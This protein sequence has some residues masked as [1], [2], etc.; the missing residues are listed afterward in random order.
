MHSKLYPTY[1]R[2]HHEP[3]TQ[4]SRRCLEVDVN[5]QLNTHTSWLNT[6]IPDPLSLLM[7][8]LKVPKGNVQQIAR[9]GTDKY[10]QSTKRSM[11]QFKEQIDPLLELPFHQ[12]CAQLRGS[13]SS[14]FSSSYILYT[15]SFIHIHFPHPPIYLRKHTLPNLLKGNI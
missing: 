6:L 1:S 9:G 11:L 5:G 2:L 4:Q 12:N 14:V 3:F 7:Q 15:I 10:A 13:S 8:G